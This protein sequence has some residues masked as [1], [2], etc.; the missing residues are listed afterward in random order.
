M[1]SFDNINNIPKH[2]S[3]KIS[4][5]IVSS[6]ICNKII[7]C[8]FEWGVT[9]YEYIQNSINSYINMIDKV[10]Y[11]FLITDSV[12]TFNIPQNVRLYRTSLLNSRKQKNE[13]LLPYIWEGINIPFYSLERGI[14]DKP[15]IGFCGLNSKYRDRTLRLFFSNKNVKSNFIIRNK[16]WGGKPHDKTIVNDFENNM[17]ESH[18]N[19]CNRGAGNFSMRF[20]QTLSA[21]RIPILLNT[22]MILPF[23]NE[24]KWNDIIVLGN[25]ED[26]LVENVIHYW[27]NKNIVEMQIKCKEIYDKYFKDSLFFDKILSE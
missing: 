19:I 4:L 15:I 26:E 12:D 17:T 22:D 24:I 16:F 2:I 9:N 23:E 5:P 6:Q 25:T 20:Y 11:I 1:I 3:E 8:K 27:C 13:Y 14:E 21:G 7:S 10:V 18:F